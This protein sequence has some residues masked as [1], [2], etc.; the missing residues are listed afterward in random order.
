MGNVLNVIS[1]V[2][3]LEFDDAVEAFSLTSWFYIHY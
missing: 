2:A 1:G 3:K